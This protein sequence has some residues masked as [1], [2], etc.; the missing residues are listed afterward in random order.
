MHRARWKVL[1]ENKRALDTTTYMFASVTALA[2][3][4]AIEHEQ[5]HERAHE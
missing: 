3:D 1:K 4:V 2:I 5:M